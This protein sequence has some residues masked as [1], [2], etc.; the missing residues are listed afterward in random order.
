[1][2][3]RYAVPLALLVVVSSSV[4][5][6]SARRDGRWEVT[7]QMEIPGMP[8]NMPPFTF[9]QC[10]TKE[11]ANNPQT[12]VPQQPQRGGPPS[13]CKTEDYK[14]TGNKATWTMRC[15]TPQPMTG[16]GE[17]TYTDDAFNGL[18]TMNM[19]RGGQ[20]MKM[21]MKMSAKRLGDCVEKK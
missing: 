12:S 9:E 6:Q 1:M 18:M 15:T 11:Q 19:E 8:A 2:N 4:F 17:V 21:T 10:V 13:D 3:A 5:A 7:S 20:A 16:T 14:L